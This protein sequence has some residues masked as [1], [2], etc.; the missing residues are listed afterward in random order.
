M[1]EQ[2][3]REPLEALQLQLQPPLDVS[4]L[5]TEQLGHDETSMGDEELT[6]D[7][8][9]IDGTQSVTSRLVISTSGR[10]P[11]S[12]LRT[13]S[14]ISRIP[15]PGR[16]PATTTPRALE[17]KVQRVGMSSDFGPRAAE[18]SAPKRPSALEARRAYSASMKARMQGSLLPT[19]A[20]AA[21]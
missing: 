5:D 8:E 3:A 6:D 20:A 17:K 7:N 18:D 16:R 14:K 19:R 15:T 12:K 21:D 1:E 13:P 4:A 10:I 11:G 2:D 9:S